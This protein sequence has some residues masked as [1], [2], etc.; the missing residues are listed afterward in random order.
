LYELEPSKSFFSKMLLYL[1]VLSGHKRI[2]IYKVTNWL[3]EARPTIFALL[4]FML[5]SHGFFCIFN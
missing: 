1:I 3:Y 2:A 4:L 5:L